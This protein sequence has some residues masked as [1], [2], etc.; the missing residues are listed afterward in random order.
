MQRALAF[1]NTPALRVPLPFFLNV[2]AFA[3]LAGLLALWAGPQAF[4][5]RW[6]PTTLALTHL[7]TLGVLGSAMLGAMMQI[8][9]VACNVPF[10]R[11]TRVSA[12]VH[13]L[14]TTGTL[15]LAWAFL[16]MR[17]WAFQASAGLLGTAFAVFIGGAGLALWRHRHQVYKGAREILVPVRAALAGLALT[18]VLGVALAGALGHGRGLPGLIDWHAL[19][20]LAG[21][22]GL[23]LIS[24]SFQL[25]PIFQVTEIYP[26]PLTRWLP[27]VIPG[28][29][30]AWTALDATDGLPPLMRETAELLLLAAYVVYA[31]TTWHLLQHRKRPRAEP[32]TWFW[33]LAMLCLIACAPLW[34]WLTGDA[35]A[36]APLTLG[37]CIIVGALWSAVNGMLY[38]IMPFLLWK[39]AQDHMVIPDHDPAQV[40]AYLLVMPKMTAYIP[41]SRALGQFV[42]HTLA[43][44]AWL[45]AGLGLPGCAWAAGGLLAVSAAWLAL[46]MGCALWTYRRTLRAMAALPLAAAAPGNTSRPAA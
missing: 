2:P 44:A 33:H 27:F 17:A 40:R 34:I 28:L 11:A 12:W 32:T 30:L 4:D 42:V 39:H 36:R 16:S 5:S 13:G 31:L 21:W 41:E 26:K 14:L 38:K 45:G 1:D 18:A 23:L 3:L 15:S 22:A 6:A 10:P 8:L 24:M 19:W 43:V 29:L 37:I 9:P 7:F 20:G 46:N 35:G 25:I